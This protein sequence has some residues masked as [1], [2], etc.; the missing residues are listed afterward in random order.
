VRGDVDAVV[1]LGVL[2]QVEGV[3]PSVW[4]DLPVI[5][6]TSRCRLAGADVGAKKPIIDEA[7]GAEGVGIVGEQGVNGLDVVDIGVDEFST[8]RGGFGVLKLLLDLG[9]VV[10]F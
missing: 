4:G 2:I 8:R 10:G 3:R 6:E 9:P 5:S 1:P 7:S